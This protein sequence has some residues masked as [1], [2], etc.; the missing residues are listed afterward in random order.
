MQVE[1]VELS[2]YR[3]EKAKECLSDAID[4]FEENRLANSVNRSYY[5][6]FHA[7]RALLAIDSFDSKKHSSIIG[8]FNQLYIANGKCD[9]SHYQMLANAFRVRERDRKII[10]Q[11]YFCEAIQICS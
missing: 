7:T 3:M 2:K 9:H 5:A 6:M 1:M 8:Y 10:S 4:A 11:G